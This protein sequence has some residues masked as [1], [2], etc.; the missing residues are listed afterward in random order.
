MIRFF[1]FS[2][3]QPENQLDL[4]NLHWIAGLISIRSSF[5]YL[6]IFSGFNMK[7]NRKTPKVKSIKN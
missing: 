3:N 1:T 2:K 6:L 4:Q 7:F 5:G